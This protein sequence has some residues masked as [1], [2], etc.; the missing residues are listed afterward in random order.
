MTGRDE[1]P[2]ERPFAGRVVLVTGASRGIGLTTARRFA[3]LGAHL[4]LNAFQD[5]GA[6]EATAE[7]CERHGV[8]VV[9]IDGDL[10]H[11]DT[12]ERLVLACVEHFGRI[13][14]VVNNAFW[15]EQASLVELSVEG[16]ERTLAVTLGAAMAVIKAALPHFEGQGGAIVNVAS[17][18]AVASVPRFAAYESAKAGLLG[19]SRSVAV[20][21][22][23][24][25]VRCNVVSPGLVLSERVERWWS[26]SAD[27]QR[28]MRA[29]IPLGRPGVPEEIARVITFLA[30]DDASFVNGAVVAVDGGATAM[31][32]ETASLR[33]VGYVTDPERS[34]MGPGAR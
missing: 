17:A 7:E 18:H 22:G 20:E 27:R 13:D 11:R 32:P 19:L 25:G 10:A 29:T 4:V 33:L 30:S 5:P 28:A 31:L 1:D 3:Y 26:G 16:W 14:V 12:A 34:S 23:C 15:E 8:G 6:L 21:Y 2:K 24:W 9:P